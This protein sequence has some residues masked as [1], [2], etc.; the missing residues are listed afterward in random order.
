MS[1]KSKNEL[2]P[3]KAALLEV[4]RELMLMQYGNYIV[5]PLYIALPVQHDG[6]TEW[7]SIAGGE[8]GFELRYTGDEPV[9][10]WNDPVVFKGQP[11]RNVTLNVLTAAIKV[12]VQRVIREGNR[13]AA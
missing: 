9:Y 3:S 1:T 7:F 12:N 10:G 5:R 11:V 4:I 8:E 6:G 2:S 13:K